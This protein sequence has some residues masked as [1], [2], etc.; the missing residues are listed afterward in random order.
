M[1]ATLARNKQTHSIK[2]LQEQTFGNDS[3]RVDREAG[4]IHDVKVLGTV[5]RNGREYSQNALKD[6][7]SILEGCQV[8]MDHNRDNPSRE[9]GFMES[10][11]TLNGLYLK[12]DGVY[13][14][15]FRVKKTHPNA[16]V[17]FES[18][19]R[20][21]KNF[22]LSINA[23]GEMVKRGGKWVVESIAKAQ[24]VDVVGKPATTDGLFESIEPGKASTVKL[25]VK[26]LIKS[27]GTAEMKSRLAKLI[28]DGGGYMDQPVDIAQPMP[29]TQVN[30][31]GDGNDNE[32]DPME[33][34]NDAFIALVASVMQ[35]ASLA[36]ADKVKQVTAILTTQ[37]SLINGDAAGTNPD[38]TV[39]EE[40]QSDGDGEEGD[41]EKMAESVKP[42]LDELRTLLIE[43]K[44]ATD[45]RQDAIEARQLL[46]ESNIKPTE[47]RVKT[48]VGEKDASKR[49]TLLESWPTERPVVTKPR[50][51]PSLRD[52]VSENRGYPSDN[53]SFVN[54][55][56]S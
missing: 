55:V 34:I 19:E 48:L 30:P 5:S 24:S 45:E 27:H 10:I 54:S 3:P 1:P 12:P 8:N 53:K 47:D 6:A 46:I 2:V 49:K 4:V 18:A 9:R 41:E 17:I 36:L 56:K 13:A 43:S 37:D 39:Q 20:F 7:C 23:E 40:D 50:V 52:D 16:P 29:D 28:E 33:Q 42:L 38:E 14:K 35:N 51:S 11:G 21:P 15:E 32:A 31:D 44:K 26:Q 22:G 25:T